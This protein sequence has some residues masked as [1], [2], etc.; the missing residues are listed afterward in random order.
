[1]ALRR[2]SAAGKAGAPVIAHDRTEDVADHGRL[3]YVNRDIEC[4]PAGVTYSDHCFVPS[5][6]GVPPW[7]EVSCADRSSPGYRFIHYRAIRVRVAP[8]EN[9]TYSG[10]N[11]TPADLYLVVAPGGGVKVLVLHIDTDVIE[12]EFHTRQALNSRT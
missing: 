6:N 7:K 9:D 4:G 8:S 5:G 11:S 12:T 3:F 10:K 2:V 1:M